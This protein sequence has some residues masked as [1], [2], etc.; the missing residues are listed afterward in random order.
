MQMKGKMVATEIRIF[1]YTFVEKLAWERCG[2]M[3]LELQHYFT[4]SL[5]IYLE[6]IHPNILP[7]LFLNTIPYHPP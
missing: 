1:I 4:L 2:D 6:N 3:V 7:L 5:P